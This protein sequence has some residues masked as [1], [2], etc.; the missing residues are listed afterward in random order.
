[1]YFSHT[2]RLWLVGAVIICSV[3]EELFALTLLA[4]DQQIR[5]TQNLIAEILLYILPLVFVLQYACM[6][7]TYVNIFETRTPKSPV[8]RLL[9]LNMGLCFNN[10][11]AALI[12][13]GLYA[14]VIVD[15]TSYL[16]VREIFNTFLDIY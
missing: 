3:I 14:G 10:I 16:L 13:L 12:A 11:L 4:T 2:R 15:S 6:G 1:M 5:Q 7:L 8:N 9:V